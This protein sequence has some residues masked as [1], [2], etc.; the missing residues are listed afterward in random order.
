MGHVD[1]AWLQLQDLEGRVRWLLPQGE[2]DKHP[3]VTGGRG[4]VCAM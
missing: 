3:E 1:G 4:P 2:W